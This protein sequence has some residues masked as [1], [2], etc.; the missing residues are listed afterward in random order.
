MPGSTA[1]TKR[2]RVVAR[3]EAGTGAEHRD[4]GVG[5]R[6]GIGGSGD[7]G[8]SET[9]GFALDHRPQQV[10]LAGEVPVHGGTGAPGLRATSSSVVLAMPTRATHVRA[11][12]STR[13][14]G[15]SIT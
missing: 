2:E 15:D 5:E 14:L 13:S 11:A 3:G 8:G 6:R 4:G 1:R 7:R 12:S 9:V 10:L